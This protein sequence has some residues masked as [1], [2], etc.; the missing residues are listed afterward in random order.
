MLMVLTL[1]AGACSG[2]DSGEP[3]STTTSETST[4]TSDTTSANSETTAGDT[5]EGPVVD[6]NAT[7]PA[8]ACAEPG[9]I[10]LGLWDENLAPIVEDAAAQWVTDYCPGAEVKIEATPWTDYWEALQIAAGGGGDIPDVLWMSPVFMPFYQQ[11]GVVVPLGDLLTEGG[12]DTS[13]W[14]T[15]SNAFTFDGDLYGAPIN[16]DTVVVAVNLDLLDQ[17]GYELPGPD[18]TW[19]DYIALGRAVSALGDDIF[20]V[21]GHGSYQNGY[22]GFLASAGVAPVLSDDRTRCTLT[23]QAS[24]DTFQMFVDLV[25]EGVAPRPDDAGGP[26]AEDYF[27]LF[28]SGRLGATTIGSWQLN[29][30]LEVIDFNWAVLPMPANPDTGKSVAISNAIAYTVTSSAE[31]P[32]LAANLVQYL[33]SDEGSRFWIEGKGFAPANLN[34]DLQNDWIA[35]F[36]GTGIDA[37]VFFDALEGSQSITVFG[38]DMWSAVNGELETR[39]FTNDEDPATVMADICTVVDAG[40]S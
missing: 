38:L 36:D 6:P 27:N 37:S 9:P 2:D 14:G 26:L 21:A 22:G 11:V 24:L 19:D 13:V 15:L 7:I 33:S 31:D 16:W 23:D 12:V 32:V 40:L 28:T 10:R 17:A 1:L 35:G 39:L 29:P 30:A 18:W 34:A 3:A 8:I 20:G 25:A 5:T 4:T